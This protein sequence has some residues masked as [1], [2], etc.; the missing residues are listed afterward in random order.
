MNENAR[1]SLQAAAA[2]GITS[3]KR[4][5]QRAVHAGF[6]LAVQVLQ[7]RPIADVNKRPR[8]ESSAQVT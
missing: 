7:H 8:V 2:L 3:C 4:H 1:E 6:Y 5:G